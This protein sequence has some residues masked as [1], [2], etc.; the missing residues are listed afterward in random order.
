MNW[1]FLSFELWL[2]FFEQHHLV[3]S[4][5]SWWSNG[6]NWR[7]LVCPTGRRTHENPSKNPP[8]SFALESEQDSGS[9]QNQLKQELCWSS[10]GSLHDHNVSPVTLSPLTQR[11]EVVR[12]V[13]FTSESSFS[14]DSAAGSRTVWT[15]VSNELRWLTAWLIT[16]LVTEPPTCQR[17]AAVCQLTGN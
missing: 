11:G 16:S 17:A 2:E 7:I 13:R 5:S 12:P 3:V 8:S 14:S 10:S 1:W 9:D 15:R 6:T 4:S